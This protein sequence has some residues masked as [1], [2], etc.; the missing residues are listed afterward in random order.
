MAEHDLKCWPGPYEGVSK[1]RKHHEIRV[2][3]RHFQVG[4]V[5][6]LREWDPHKSEYT[7][8]VELR[9]RVTYISYGPDWGLPA[10]LVVM[11]IEAAR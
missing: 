6:V 1:G 4:D 11:S 3:D 8:A 2:N 7:R 9:R 5:L 10:G